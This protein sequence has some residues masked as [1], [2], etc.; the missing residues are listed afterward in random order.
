MKIL[1][2]I[3]PISGSGAKGKKTIPEKIERYLDKDKFDYDIVFTEYMGH[4]EKLAHKAVEDKYDIV[5]AVGGDGTV[6]EVAR[7]LTHSSS[8]LGIIPCGSGN[9][10]ARHL[11]IPLDVVKDIELINQCDIMD[12]DYG[13]INGLPFFCTCGMGF[14]AFISMKFAEKGKRGLLGYLENVLKEG[15][16]Y[17][18][19]TYIIED[20]NGT[21]NYEAFLVACAN[22]SQYGN[23]AFIAP[24]ATMNDGLLDVV[25]MEPF[26]ALEAPQISIDLLNRS[27][28]QNS[29]VKTFRTKKLTVKREHPGEIHYDGEPIISDA[30]VD[31]HIETGGIKIVVNSNAQ[32]MKDP[33]P[34]LNAFSEFFNNVNSV[35]ED[36]EYQGRR[37]KAINKLLLRRLSK[38]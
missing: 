4:A 15:L 9:G 18:P 3:N 35:K 10:L 25:I 19:E 7:A 8:A 13:V 31:I 22:A 20:E 30:E 28:N 34:L 5:V 14:D 1:F 24:Q 26:T 6:N 32:P 36:I 27:M 23:D 2:I 33:N 29:K 16:S 38:S 12:L 21:H 17:K 37:V 11:Q